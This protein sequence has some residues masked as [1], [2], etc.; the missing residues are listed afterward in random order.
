MN[1]VGMVHSGEVTKGS[2]V[3]VYDQL[4]IECQHFTLIDEFI[5]FVSNHTTA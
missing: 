4:S 2:V 5:A 3:S 1:F